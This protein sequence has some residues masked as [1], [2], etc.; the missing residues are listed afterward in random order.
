MFSIIS[1]NKKRT[2][3]APTYITKKAIG[4]NSKLN[5]NNTAATLKKEKIKNKTENIGFLVQT[6]KTD[7]VRLNAEKIIKR[8]DLINI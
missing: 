4:K 2:A 3:T 6:T 1:T 7:D 8:L 5:K